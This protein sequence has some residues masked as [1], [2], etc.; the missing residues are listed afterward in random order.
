MPFYDEEPDAI[1]KSLGCRAQ[2]VE[3]AD[4]DPAV[5]PCLVSLTGVQCNRRDRG[6]LG[7]RLAAVLH[8]DSDRLGIAQ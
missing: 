6:D 4:P 1:G 8:W 7:E 5:G 2:T 3:H